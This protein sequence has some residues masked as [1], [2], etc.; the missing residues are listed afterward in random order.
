MKKILLALLF[1]ITLFLTYPANIKAFMLPPDPLKIRLINITSDN[2]L[3]VEQPVTGYFKIKGLSPFTNIYVGSS[4][5][6]LGAFVLDPRKYLLEIESTSKNLEVCIGGTYRDCG[7]NI[8]PYLSKTNWVTISIPEDKKKELTALYADKDP[9][10]IED[11]QII[12]T[13][14]RKQFTIQGSIDYNS[15][16]LS[17]PKPYNYHDALEQITI[18]DLAL[19]FII[20]VSATAFIYAA[21]NYKKAMN[22][23][24]FF[25]GDLNLILK[26]AA[27]ILI[28]FLSTVTLSTKVDLQSYDDC[29]GYSIYGNKGLP[30]PYSYGDTYNSSITSNSFLIIANLLFW[31]ILFLSA[32]ELLTHSG[33]KDKNFNT[34]I[35]LKRNWLFIGATIIG[36]IIY[37]FISIFFSVKIFC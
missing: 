17:S 26:I 25:R 21:L 9:V 13:I 32:I 37:N 30:F 5:I 27:I 15:T 7:L 28:F 34:G 11:F 1:L 4:S 33:I 8:N 3:V 36:Y 22:K 20:A 2:G 6:E 10:K 16:L 14:D 23:N 18:F 29:N 19:Y 12:V 31:L 35:F 24:I